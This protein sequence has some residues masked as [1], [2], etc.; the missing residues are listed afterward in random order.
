MAADPLI[1]LDLEEDS[2]VSW[3]LLSHL[4]RR[5]PSRIKISQT[6]MEY[7]ILKRTVDEH[8]FDPCS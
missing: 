6:T 3:L 1:G 2:T 7:L 5:S 8:L 4:L